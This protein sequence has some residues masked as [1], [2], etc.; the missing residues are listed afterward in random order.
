VEPNI[1]RSPMEENETRNNAAQK[2]K[3]KEIFARK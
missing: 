3:K 1:L 2:T